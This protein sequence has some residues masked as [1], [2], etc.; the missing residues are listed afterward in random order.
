M[1]LTEGARVLADA[2]DLMQDNPRIAEIAPERSR[3]A[4]PLPPGS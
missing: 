4:L 1:L 2:V 3:S